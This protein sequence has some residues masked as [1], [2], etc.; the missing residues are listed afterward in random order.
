MTKKHFYKDIT[1]WFDYPEVI[2]L[3]I[4]GA[5][6]GDTIVETGT[7]YGASLAYAGV[8][9]NKPGR[10]ISYISFDNDMSVERLDSVLG[11]AERIGNG[12][13]LPMLGN[14]VKS[15]KQFPNESLH[16][17][18]LDACHDYDFVKEEIAAWWPKVKRGGIFSGHD[19]D[20]S[21]PGVVKAVQEFAA[22]NNLQLQTMKNC[23]IIYKP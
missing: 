6:D 12:N 8:E 13:I 15:S 2:D 21:W 7:Y 5:V 23:W 10:Q 3:L 22:A 17:V 4:S 16:A 11:V 14:S 20:A 19:Y 18:F 1:G 9:I